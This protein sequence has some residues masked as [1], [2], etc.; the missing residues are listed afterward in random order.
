MEEAVNVLLTHLDPAGRQSLR[1]IPRSDL[2]ERT[3]EI[4]AWIRNEFGLWGGRSPL[5]RQRLSLTGDVDKDIGAG[6][7]R[8]HPDDVSV[9]IIRNAWERLQQHPAE[10]SAAADRQGK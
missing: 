1:A 3:W 8:P 5:L 4:A 7:D 6:F 9:A 2:S 10:P